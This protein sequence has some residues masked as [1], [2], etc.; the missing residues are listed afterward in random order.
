MIHSTNFIFAAVVL[1]YK[2]V[3]K[4]GLPLN[5]LLISLTKK[6]LS[7]FSQQTQ[8]LDIDR[9]QYVLVLIQ[10][11]N[12]MLSQQALAEKLEVD[13]S[14]VVGI[15]NYLEGKGYVRREK[16]ENDRRQQMIKLTDKANED[17]PKIRAVTER[18]NS[19]SLENF[20]ED[21]IKTL[22]SMLNQIESNL[23]DIKPFNIIINYKKSAPK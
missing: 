6:Y 23:V 16:N 7:V 13:K 10:D 15:I 22:T 19:K 21:Q 11:N 18:L 5:R 12:E 17:I 4:D 3:N 20:S 14:Y 1:S 2:M 8:G 9:Y